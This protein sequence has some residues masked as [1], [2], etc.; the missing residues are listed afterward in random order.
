MRSIAGLVLLAGALACAG[1][2][3]LT[4]EEPSAAVG[5]CF[6]GGGR[7]DRDP[8]RKRPRCGRLAARFA[9]RTGDR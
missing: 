3:R 9:F 4:R 2:S 8:D 1:L 6:P 5:D 7:A